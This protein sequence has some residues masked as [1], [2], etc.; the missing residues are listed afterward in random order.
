MYLHVVLHDAPSEWSHHLVLP[1]TNAMSWLCG[2][3]R[4]CLVT[5]KLIA[6][7]EEH[8]CHYH[9]KPDE[10]HDGLRLHE[11]LGR[12]RF[13]DQCATLECHLYFVFS[14]LF[15]ALLLCTSFS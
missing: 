8:D 13:L 15:F 12:N 3:L 10:A 9:L 4:Q 2:V 7:R 6:N 14:I 5:S 11:Y 1:A